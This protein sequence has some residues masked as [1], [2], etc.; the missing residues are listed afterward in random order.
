M[1][2]PRAKAS[3]DKVNSLLSCEFHSP[4]NGLLPH[5]DI[6]CILRCKPLQA[7][8]EDRAGDGKEE[9]RKQLKGPIRC[10][11]RLTDID[12]KPRSWVI[13]R[14]GSPKLPLNQR[15]NMKS[16]R[17]QVFFNRRWHQNDHT[18]ATDLYQTKT[19]PQ[20]AGIQGSSGRFQVP[21]LAQL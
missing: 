12:T 8:M 1:T 20:Y 3:Q 5:V 16:S 17:S 7:S 6:L 19:E 9:K 14:S 15:E 18:I 4:L 2:W 21:Q 11:V 10:Q 13:P